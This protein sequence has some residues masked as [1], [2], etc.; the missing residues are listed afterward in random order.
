MRLFSF[1]PEVVEPEEPDLPPAAGGKQTAAEEVDE[2]RA[3]R[4]E[5]KRKANAKK[6]AKKHAENGTTPPSAPPPREYPP[7]RGVAVVEPA[8]KLRRQQPSDTG[9]QPMRDETASR[10][11]ANEGKAAAA[12]ATYFDPFTRKRVAIGG[13]SAAALG[14]SRAQGAVAS[15]SGAA[16]GK[17]GAKKAPHVNPSPDSSSPEDSESDSD[18]ADRRAAKKAK[19]SKSAPPSIP[20]PATTRSPGKQKTG[21]RDSDS[22][23]SSSSDSSEDEENTQRVVVS[24][25]PKSYYDPFTKK[26]ITIAGQE[27]GG[28]RPAA[29][30]APVVKKPVPG[31]DEKVI[32]WDGAS[33]SF[34]IRLVKR[35]QS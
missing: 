16:G 30:S 25:A 6:I 7:W 4:R 19:G 35:W 34:V 14:D 17:A 23:S 27:Q 22:S 2:K 3:K 20:S 9:S 11:P 12:P 13:G 10:E 15:S 28:A 32:P 21:S 5:K 29:T 24:S 8:W 31:K 1:G 33:Q 26:R 18:Q